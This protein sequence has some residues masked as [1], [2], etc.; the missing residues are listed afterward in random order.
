MTQETPTA[1]AVAAVADSMLD[2]FI[3]EVVFEVHREAKLDLSCSCTPATANAP[4]HTHHGLV[5]APGLDIFGQKPQASPVVTC[6]N[7]HMPKQATKLAQHLELCMGVG[8]RESRRGGGT[9]S[10]NNHQPPAPSA[11]KPR[12]S[13]NSERRRKP[14]TKVSAA[15]EDRASKRPRRGGNSSAPPVTGAD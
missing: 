8:G 1:A 7:C 2:F 15:L 9:R 11:P 4:N 10:R 13:E 14:T 3:W 5:N 12:A 6:P